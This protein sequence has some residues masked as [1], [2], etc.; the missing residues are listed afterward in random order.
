MLFYI[1][2]NNPSCY[3]T[4]K[5]STNTFQGSEPLE[6][7]IN[8]LSTIASFLIT[9][10]DDYITFKTKTNNVIS[11]PITFNFDERCK[12]DRDML[13]FELTELF[14]PLSDTE[15][16][17]QSPQ[18]EEQ[19]DYSFIVKD[20]DSGTLTITS[21]NQFSIIDASHRAKLLLGLYNTEL[22]TPYTNSLKINSVPYTCYGNNLYLKSRISN[23]VGFMDSMNRET[24]IS[25]CYHIFEIFYPNMP[26]ICRIP[27]N[28]IKIK[29]T[30]LTNMEFSL[31]DFQDEPVLLKA[32]LNIVME[33][34]YK[35]RSTNS[36]LPINQNI[37]QV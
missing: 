17:G 32:P 8:Q 28:I 35:G 34:F 7:R 24:Y 26:I 12:Y 29:P 19:N 23:I 20:N 22:P 30:D 21:E 37:L 16:R 11:E 1:R 2:S 31:V 13:A 9:T 18:L 14:E 25:I 6:F 5:F 36:I 4:V 33:V 3:H 27:G 15:P 10:T